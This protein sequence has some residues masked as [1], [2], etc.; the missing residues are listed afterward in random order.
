MLKGEPATKGL[1]EEDAAG[2]DDKAPISLFL[3]DDVK[4][5]DGF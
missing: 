1:N 4:T 3:V 5:A 2:A